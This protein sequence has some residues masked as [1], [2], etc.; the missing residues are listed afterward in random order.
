[1]FQWKL[2]EVS[3]SYRSCLRKMELKSRIENGWKGFKG[4]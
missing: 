1:M 2:D 4:L 3:A